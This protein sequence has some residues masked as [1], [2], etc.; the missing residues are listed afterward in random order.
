MI[1]LLVGLDGKFDLSIITY[2]KSSLN[3]FWY[4]LIDED[5][6][7]KFHNFT[8]TA[9]PEAVTINDLDLLDL[10]G[11][12]GKIKKIELDPELLLEGD[13]TICRNL[14]IVFEPE[15]NCKLRT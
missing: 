4:V 12:Y 13:P 1:F 3:K 9:K 11:R 14:R 7:E 8:W 2:A 6:N 10:E 5:G 15:K